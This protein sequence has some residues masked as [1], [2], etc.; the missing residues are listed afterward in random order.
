MESFVIFSIL[1]SYVGVTIY[2]KIKGK[3]P[4]LYFLLSLVIGP[5]AFIP[6]L[7]SNKPSSSSKDKF[8]I[9]VAD[10]TK[11]ANG[12]TTTVIDK[13]VATCPVCS[14]KLKKIPGAKTKCPKCKQFMF[15]RTDSKTMSRVVVD[16]KQAELIDEEWAKISGTWE[17]LKK[18][19][20]RFIKTKSDLSEKFGAEASDA[21]TKWALLIEDSLSHSAMQNWGHYRN[22]IFQMG[23]QLRKEGKMKHALEKFL[24]VCYLDTCGPNNISTPIGR[25]HEFGMKPFTPDSSSMA[26]GIISRVEKLAQKVN[27]DSK[28]LETIFIALEMQYKD[29]IPFSLGV[30]ESWSQIKKQINVQPSNL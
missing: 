24:L 21:D 15:V 18:E 10:L 26:P 9:T 13:R 25:Q 22:T 17:S 11:S 28:K 14:A 20:E 16:A 7:L 27:Y 30:Q 6:L 5:F 29:A 3:N 4:F 8:T 1:L 12:D 23:E 19:K 2:A